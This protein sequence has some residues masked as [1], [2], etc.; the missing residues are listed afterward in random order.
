MRNPFKKTP[1]GP[2][3]LD[4]ITDDGDRE[5]MVQLVKSGAD[6]DQPREMIFCV[7]A[8]TENVEDFIKEIKNM[9]WDCE[10]NEAH[11]ESGQIRAD[12]WFVEIK[13]DGYVIAP[14]SFNQDRQGIEK[15]SLKYNADYDGWYASV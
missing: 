4:Q 11:D 5:V 10:V 12:E 9:D 15:L 1:P 14:Q 7:Y 2:E 6:L 3:W 8:K 13:R